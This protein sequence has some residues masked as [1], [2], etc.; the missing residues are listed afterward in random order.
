MMSAIS[1]GMS[2]LSEDED[3]QTLTA[4]QDGRVAGDSHALTAVWLRVG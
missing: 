3:E 2:V 4:A 1:D